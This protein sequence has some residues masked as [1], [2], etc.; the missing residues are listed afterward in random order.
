MS[1]PYT[2]IE[3][4]TRFGKL[5]FIEDVSI[6]DDGRRRGKFLCDCGRE[7]VLRTHLVTAGSQLSCGCMRGKAWA[8]TEEE[9]QRMLEMANNM[10]LTAIAQQLNR[11]RVTVRNIVKAREPKPKVNEGFFDVDEFF[12]SDFILMA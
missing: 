7:K 3:P 12:R 5:K 6:T 10:T 1:R 4:G 2:P 11:D 8:V 9:K